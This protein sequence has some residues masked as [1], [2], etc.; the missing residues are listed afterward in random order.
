MHKKNLHLICEQSQICETVAGVSSEC[1]FETY[2]SNSISEAMLS[3]ARYEPLVVVIDAILL[4][5]ED[6]SFLKGLTHNASN[7]LCLF[8]ILLTD[9]N[10]PS[11]SYTTDLIAANTLLIQVVYLAK[12]SLKKP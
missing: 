6:I 7:N 10:S 9:L 4:K 2:Q 12:K 11:N 5:P 3:F 8:F 1:G